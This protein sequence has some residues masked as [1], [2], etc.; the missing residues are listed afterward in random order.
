MG[1]ESQIVDTLNKIVKAVEEYR[2][3]ISGPSISATINSEVIGISLYDIESIAKGILS[4]TF[5]L[6]DGSWSLD[7]VYY[8]EIGKGLPSVRSSV[9]YYLKKEVF[10]A[11]P[12]EMGDMD[13]YM[14]KDLYNEKAS[15]ADMEL[16]LR[17]V[18]MLSRRIKTFDRF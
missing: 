17:C 18:E 7:V 3:T 14:G 8:D 11:R 16:I 15:E 4:A 1:I 9:R 10:Y 2:G 6:R 5:F 13:F 12:Y